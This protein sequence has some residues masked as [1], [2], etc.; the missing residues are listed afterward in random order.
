MAIPVSVETWVTRI[1][2][3]VIQAAVAFVAAVAHSGRGV[4]QPVARWVGQVRR[5]RRSAGFG[6]FLRSEPSGEAQRGWHEVK[7][8]ATYRI[9]RG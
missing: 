7:G 1:K 2:R 3:T 6:C 9:G 5:H 4:T 8:S